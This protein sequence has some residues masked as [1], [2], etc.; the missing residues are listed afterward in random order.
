MKSFGRNTSHRGGVH[1]KSS[2]RVLVDARKYFG[3]GIGVYVQNLVHG[4]LEKKVVVGLIV[5]ADD[6]AELD[7]SQP[8]LLQ[9][10]RVHIDDAK[11]YSFNEIFLLAKRLPLHEY[12]VFHTPH[13]ILPF[14]IKIPSVVT[15]HD[16]IHITAGE[17][18][19]YPMVARKLIRSAI[20]R[21]SLVVTV[22][23]ASAKEL[24][25][26]FSIDVNNKLIVV[27][28][29]VGRNFDRGAV[30]SA[31]AGDYLLAV[32]SNLK[33][34]KGFNELLLAYEKYAYD[35]SE[36]TL[37]LVLA[38]QGVA[39][40]REDD[41]PKKLRRFIKVAG[42][43]SSGGLRD[44]YKNARALLVSSFAEGFCLPV[45]EA[46]TQ[47]T[48][49]LIRPVEAPAELLLNADVQCSDFSVQAFH[50]GIK[51]ILAKPLDR[52]ALLSEFNAQVADRY[53]LAGTS[54]QMVRGYEK[55]LSQ[56]GCGV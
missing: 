41:F 17:K 15:I 16:I 39:H 21:A 29:S 38:G 10:V 30:L 18:F 34:H 33:P 48:P 56:E 3:G 20:R 35:E 43:Q 24:R 49:V 46:H 51:E 27:P 22:S 14:G 25:K 45:L 52:N 55:I 50:E 6:A 53:S 2:L 4:L 26:H 37:P 7:R 36:S 54:N 28:N 40:L 12:D 23:E 47:G 8:E 31:G 5:R 19:F 9:S 42:A 32:F 44:L 11:P 13:Y 1:L